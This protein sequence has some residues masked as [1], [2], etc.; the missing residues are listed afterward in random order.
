MKL[1]PYC[2]EEIQDAAVRCKHCRSDLPAA[3][4]A[5]DPDR[6]AGARAGRRVR[7]LLFGL[8]GVAALAVAS[9]V[10][11]RPLLGKLRASRC[12]PVGIM[13]WHVAMKRRCLKPSYVCEHMTT[14]KMLEDPEVVRS[15]SRDAD[16]DPSLAEMVGR[17]RQAFGCAP[18]AGPAWPAAPPALPTP[19]SPVP[20]DVPRSL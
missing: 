12:E 14:R 8:C 16:E 2:A 3:A 18:E 20:Q 15:F 10:V 5:A 9:P 4:P 17:M 7:W 1:C 19:W 13:E 6:A 11:A